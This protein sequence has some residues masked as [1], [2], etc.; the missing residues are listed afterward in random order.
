MSNSPSVEEQLRDWI[1]QLAPEH[2]QLLLSMLAEDDRLQRAARLDFAVTELR[3][4]CSERGLDW[5]TMA[6]TERETF[7]DNLIRDNELYS[8]QIDKPS[9]QAVVP[10]FQCGR[11]MTPNDLYRIYFGERRP[12]VEGVTAKLVVMDVE[13]EAQFPLAIDGEVTIGRLDPHRGIRPEVDLSKYD[14][15]SRISRRHARII[16]R[17]NQF[18]VED[19]GSANGTIINGSKRL[20]PTEPYPL[21]NGDVLK[22]GETTLKFVG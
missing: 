8:T 13:I 12:S 5:D 7:L 17:G 9:P 4:L 2:K 14:P 16:V 15:A 19:L 6:E 18:F 11:E 20:K 21:A 3:R 22:I 1:N 10:C